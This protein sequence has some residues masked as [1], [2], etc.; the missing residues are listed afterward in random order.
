M[1]SIPAN[2]AEIPALG[3]GT[4]TLEGR[5]ARD[6]VAAAIAAGWRH[7]DTAAMY[8]N[9]EEVGAGIR[10]GGVARDRLF[11]T[12]K[13]WHSDLAAR[14][15]RRSAEASLKRLRLDA[16]DLLLVHWPNPRI[17]L[18]ETIGA[19]NRAREDG[20]TRHIGVSNFP[21][22]L[23]AEA[24]RLS[25]APVAANQVEHHPYLDQEKVLRACRAAGA[26]LVGY[27]PLHRGGALLREKAVAEAAAAHGRTPAQIA[28]RW[29]VQQEGV[30][31]I[32]RTSNPA[33]LAE[34]L[35]VFD[36]ELSAAE[37]QAISSLGGSGRR[38][39]DYGFSPRW[40]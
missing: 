10:A 17:P 28:L 37:M 6:M 34:N 24:V 31:A 23:F 26:A 40:D 21:T 39:C 25:D 30:A 38:L 4:W 13:V 20:V 27:C 29:H 22:A 36:F 14:D 16:V 11:V 2:G 8:G 9:E 1:H 33:R 32:P 35:D 19:L 7:I 12:T 3:F 5:T 15:L 18:A